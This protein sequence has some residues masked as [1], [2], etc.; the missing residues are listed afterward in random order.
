M[1]VWV[2]PKPGSR[3]FINNINNILLDFKI[4]INSN[5]VIESDFSTPFFPIDRPSEQKLISFIRTK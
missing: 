3:H 1:C 4:K 2:L 5:S